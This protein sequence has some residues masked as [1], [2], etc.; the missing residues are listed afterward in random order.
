M[1]APVPP[2]P[3]VHGGRATPDDL[4]RDFVGQAEKLGQASSGH[5]NRNFVLP[6][7][8]SVAWLVG[9]DAGTSVTVRV[10]RADALPVVIRTWNDEAQ[11]LD[12]IRGVL[13][14]APQCLIK[15]DGFS[16]HSYVDGVPLSSVCGDGK[17]VDTLL[18]RALAGLL[19]Q[20]AQV[21]RGALPPLP[22]A[23][24]R[25]D[26]DSQGFLQTLARLADRQIRQ[27]NWLAFGGLFAAL[28]IP[29]DALIRFAERVPAMA[30]R[31]YSLLHADLHRDN[32]I[33][34]YDGAPPLIC[35]DWELATYGDPL[36]D[37][38][39]HLVR[40]RYPSQ[41][42]AEVIDAWAEAMLEIRPAAVNGLGKDLPRYV[43]F[44]R[45]Q[46]VYPD[47]MRAARS[48]EEPFTQKRL[49]EATA[50]V[51]R[52]VEAAAEPLRLGNVPSGPEIERAL[53]RWLASRSHGGINGRA[54]V[55]KA[56]TWKPDRRLGERPDFPASAVRKALLVEGPPRRA[57]CSRGLHTSTRSSPCPGSTSPS[58]CG[59]GCPASAAG[60][61]A[62]S[63]STPCFA[64]SKRRPWTWRRRR[65]SRWARATRAIPSPSTPMWG[66]ATFLP[67][68][69]CTGCSRTRRTGWSTSSAP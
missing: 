30:R 37:L 9:L 12:A 16:I 35:V 17:P 11:I 50:E 34:S 69:P 19:A 3:A 53:F 36:H 67:A 27:P 5:H 68:T 65:P 57:G 58:S 39:T 20:M 54:W 38:A 52:A 22:T 41:Q 44:E 24:P 31:P 26:T 48:L 7:T 21:R 47:V 56:F 49:D 61:P 33:V 8:G 18:V 13:P 40:M 32:L 59:A 45:A 28:G 23:W 43:A 51:L 15:R 4:I 25:N 29:E 14:H 64:R 63:A 6:L 42:W 10:R 62:T 2:R 1:R 46:S 55:R 66:R 60:S